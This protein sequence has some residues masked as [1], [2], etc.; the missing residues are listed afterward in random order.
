MSP[1]PFAGCRAPRSGPSHILWGPGDWATARGGCRMLDILAPPLAEELGSFAPPYLRLA[2]FGGARCVQAF[3][4]TSC[5]RASELAPAWPG[6]LAPA[7]PGCPARSSAPA[8]LPS[9]RR[10]RPPSTSPVGLF[11]HKLLGCDAGRTVQRGQRCARTFQNVL[12]RPLLPHAPAGYAPRLPR[13]WWCP[14]LV[15]S[16]HRAA[17]P[18]D[19]LKSLGRAACTG[20]AGRAPST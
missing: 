9:R 14:W 6:C 16:S 3:A 8:W 15:P 5:L 1:G 12:T 13:R 20:R 19:F 18:S 4:Y 17:G 7:S 10:L 11:R 2:L